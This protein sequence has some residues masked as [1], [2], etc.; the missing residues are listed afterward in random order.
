MGDD[1]LPH[2]MTA[3]LLNMGDDVLHHM[4]TAAL[5]NTGDDVLHH[6]EAAALLS[7]VPAAHL[8]RRV[9]ASFDIR[10]LDQNMNMC[11]FRNQ[12]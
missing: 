4:M 7:M 8:C 6:M 9:A 5:L 11:S 12:N 2:M 3:A 1:V 10:V